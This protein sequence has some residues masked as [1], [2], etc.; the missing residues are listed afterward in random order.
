MTVSADS[1]ST[2]ASTPTRPY[3]PFIAA[4]GAVAT[5]VTVVA[6][7]GETGRFA[8]TVSAMCSVSADP[9]LVLVCINSRSPINEAIH[10]NGAFTVNVL[11]S[12]H[13][14]VAD[15]FAG[16]PWPG[17][18]PWDFSCGQWEPAPSGSP[19]IAD[20][21][22]SFDCSI[23]QMVEAGTHRIYIGLVTNVET[24]GG[25]PLIYSAQTYAKPLPV[26]P[27][28]FDDYPGSGPT[29]RKNTK[30]NAT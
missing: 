28:V 18:G 12:Q 21:V 24:H 27:S 15:T 2:A 20:A 19:R 10:A 3:D 22:A 6:T 26:P 29:Y 1:T 25:D 16:R 9:R 30:E 7:E 23:H 14:H 11:G 8:Q 4:M 17:K 13:D 5:G